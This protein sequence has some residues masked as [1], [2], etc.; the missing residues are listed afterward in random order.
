MLG[1]TAM[2]P[3]AGGTRVRTAEAGLP[4]RDLRRLLFATAA[5]L[6][7]S[8]LCLAAALDPRATRPCLVVAAALRP[9]ML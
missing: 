4:G 3:E 9:A 6:L 1:R 5:G 7:F 2:T 8:A